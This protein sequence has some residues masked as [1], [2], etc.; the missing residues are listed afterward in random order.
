MTEAT[1]AEPQNPEK[2]QVW[3][4]WFL[5]RVPAE[6]RATIS[7]DHELVQASRQGGFEAT[8]PHAKSIAGGGLYEA[9]AAVPAVAD[10][11]DVPVDE[12][13]LPPVLPDPWVAVSILTL[14]VAG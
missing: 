6:A 8:R 1:E 7:W 12:A 13:A 11:P 14:M 2:L 10:V 5:A 4:G 3:M 9:D